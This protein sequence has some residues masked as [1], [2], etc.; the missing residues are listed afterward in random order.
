MYHM[1][2]DMEGVE[3]ANSENT[4]HPL[5]ADP[6]LLS[7]ASFLCVGGTFLNAPF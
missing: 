6:P 1:M 4:A 3:A 2:I 7:D 5:P